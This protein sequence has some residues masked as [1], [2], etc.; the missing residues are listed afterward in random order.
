MR[1][2]SLCYDQR[3]ENG[4]SEK[5]VLNLPNSSEKTSSIGYV[6]DKAAIA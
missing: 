3:M 5:N 2:K 6:I 4:I 1:T